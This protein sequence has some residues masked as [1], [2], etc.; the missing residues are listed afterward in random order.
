MKLSVNSNKR[1]GIAVISLV[2]SEQACQKQEQI[3]QAKK[4]VLF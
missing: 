3:C 1:N 4:K 2:L